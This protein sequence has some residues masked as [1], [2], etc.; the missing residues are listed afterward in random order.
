MEYTKPEIEIV[1]FENPHDIVTL[2]NK[3]VGGS[4]GGTWDD[5]TN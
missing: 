4:D 2:S 5:F 1:L 3:V